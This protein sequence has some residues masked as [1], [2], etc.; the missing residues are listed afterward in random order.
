MS[1]RQ[2]VQ[3][4]VAPTIKY[5]HVAKNT[6][7]LK[8]S[9][10]GGAVQSLVADKEWQ[11]YLPAALHTRGPCQITVIE[12]SISMY[13]TDAGSRAALAEVVKMWVQTNIH[14]QGDDMTTPTGSINSRGYD[15]LFDVDFFYDDAHRTYF[16]KNQF[17]FRCTGLPSALQFRAQYIDTGTAIPVGSLGAGYTPGYPA[18]I[19]ANVS[20]PIIEF[21]LEV[22]F[23]QD[24][25]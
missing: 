1:T 17:T 18:D 9:N 22:E 2:I 21:H 7:L 16:M 13:G 12:G 8:I 10:L 25:G 15:E 5:L 3:G 19:D 24:L 11:T 20:K 6:F 4:K 14:I 23:D